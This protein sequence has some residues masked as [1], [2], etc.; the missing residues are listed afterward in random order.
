MEETLT[1][2]EYCLKKKLPPELAGIYGRAGYTTATIVEQIQENPDIN[3][4][5]IIRATALRL[6]QDR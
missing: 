2:I 1:I 4:V 6:E 5:E 3:L